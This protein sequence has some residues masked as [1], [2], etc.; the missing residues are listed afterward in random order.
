MCIYWGEGGLKT[1]SVPVSTS[2]KWRAS[3]EKRLEI[4]KADLYL[5]SN[6]L[7][8]VGSGVKN[9]YSCII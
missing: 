2:G 6:S 5:I 7:R 8:V 4:V 3:K 1:K 9:M